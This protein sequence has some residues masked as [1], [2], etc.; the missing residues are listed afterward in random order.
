[1]LPI[2]IP[3]LCSDKSIVLECFPRV[4]HPDRHFL[5]PSPYEDL[6]SVAAVGEEGCNLSVERES[7]DHAIGIT[8]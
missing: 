6:P 3:L 7:N 8:Y 4:Q 1:M 5:S 2:P